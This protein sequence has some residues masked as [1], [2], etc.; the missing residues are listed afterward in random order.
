MGDFGLFH[1]EIGLD[2]CTFGAFAAPVAVAA[3]GNFAAGFA[4]VFGAG[5]L[6]GVFAAAC[7]PFAAAAC[8][9]FRTFAAA[10]PSVFRRPFFRAAVVPPARFETFDAFDGGCCCR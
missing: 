4:R 10:R 9:A 5:F 1:A 6:L 3:A 7:A 8:P 2:Q